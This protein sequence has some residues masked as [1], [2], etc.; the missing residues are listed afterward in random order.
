MSIKIEKV[1][2][3]GWE[4]AVRGA[5]NAKESWDRSDSQGSNLGPNDLKLLSS[6]AKGG[7]EES[8]SRRNIIVFMDVVAPLYW[9]KQADTYK[10]GTVKQSCSTMHRV[11]CHEF[12]TGMFSHEHLLPE[13]EVDFRSKSY[14]DYYIPELAGMAVTRY[15][16]KAYFTPKGFLRMICDVLNRYRRLFLDTKDKKYWWQIIQLLPSS[17]MQ[18]ATL[19]VNYEV[20]AAMYHQRKNHKLGEWHDFCAWIETLPYAKELIVDPGYRGHRKENEQ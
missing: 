18:R 10:V 3:Y 15:G 7:G 16:E 13:D 20:L 11:H 5:R 4:E 2:I 1:S 9:W 8:K 17:Y 14:D 19:Q 12:E 6:L